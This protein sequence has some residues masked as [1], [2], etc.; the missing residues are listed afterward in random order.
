M[1]D[2]TAR[3][4]IDPPLSALDRRLAARGVTANMTTMAGLALGLAAAFASAMD[5]VTFGRI[6]LFRLA[7][8]LDGAVA[9]ASRKSDFGGYL[10]VTAD[11]LFYGAIPED[12]CRRTQRQ[13]R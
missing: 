8:G 12:S 7:D 6:L 13:M 1:L 11:F 2:A 3:K 4:L 9:R 5:T 10:D